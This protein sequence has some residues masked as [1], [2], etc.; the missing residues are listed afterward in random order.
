MKGKDKHEMTRSSQLKNSV[1][2]VKDLCPSIPCGLSIIADDGTRRTMQLKIMHMLV[3]P[4]AL[5]RVDT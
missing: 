5:K 1:S 2:I 4:F 3:P